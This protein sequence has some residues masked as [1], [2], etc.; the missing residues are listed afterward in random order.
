LASMGWVSQAQDVRWGWEWR[1][2]PC[3]GQATLSAQA[4]SPL[5]MHA[6]TRL[7]FLSSLLGEVTAGCSHHCVWLAALDACWAVFMDYLSYGRCYCCAQ[8]PAS[9]CRSVPVCFLSSPCGGGVRECVCCSRR[10][11]LVFTPTRSAPWD[12]VL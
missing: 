6:C 9:P 2:L 1:P 5:C 12:V 8:G 7:F 11:L 4:Q 10:P 3:L